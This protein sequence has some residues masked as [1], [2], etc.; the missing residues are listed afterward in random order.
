MAQQPVECAELASAMLAH[1]CPPVFL[2]TA[3]IL[4]TL[5]VPFRHDLQVDI[6]YSAASIVDDALAHPN[7]IWAVK[8]ANVIQEFQ[9]NRESIRTELWEQI[10]KLN[11][12]I[13]RVSSVAKIL[14]PERRIAFPEWPELKFKERLLGIMDRLVESLVIYRGTRE[15]VEKARNRLWA[16]IPPTGKGKQ[17]KDCE[18]FEEFLELLALL[19]SKAFDQ[20]AVFVTPNKQD[21][22]PAPDGF[23]EIGSDLAACGAR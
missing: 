8:T 23:P 6:V 12:S 7:L 15:C 10:S 13:V 1:P 18:I 14:F 21:Y 2:D 17:F 19:R 22:G 11:D 5:R 9:A 4:D 16:G 3:A 20:A